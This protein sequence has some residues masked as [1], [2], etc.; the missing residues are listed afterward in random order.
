MFR[1]SLTIAFVLIFVL[2]ASS[3]SAQ[4]VLNEFSIA[5]YDGFQ[6][7]GDY[8]DWVEIY[9][10]TGAAIDAGGY[11]LSDNP[12]NPTKFE[13]PAG[14]NVPAGGYLIILLTND[15]DADPFMYGYLN[16]TFRVNQTQ[17]ESVI[18]ADPGGA[19]LTEWAF[20][21]VISP[22]QRNHSYG[23]IGDGAADWGI[24]TNPTPGGNN[25]T[26]AFT[27]YAAVPQFDTDAGYFAG[28]LTVGISAE[29]GSDIYYTTDGTDPDP[30]DQLYT[31]PIT[32][33]QT[34]VIRAIAYPND[35]DL[36]PSFV[37]TNTYFTGDDQHSV[38]VC[39][40]SGPTLSDG[41]WFGDEFMAIEMFH[42]NG[43]FWTEAAGDS[44]EHGNDSNAY[45]Q[46]GFDYVGR[47]ELGYKH[48]IDE[49]LFHVKERDL[50]QRL[51]F[52]AAANDNYPFE[53]GAHIRD[54]FVQ[55]LSHN[56]ELRLDERTN[57]SCI[58]YINGEYWGVYEYR[59]K[60]DDLDFTEEYYDQSRHFV[61]FIKTWGGTWEE[62][63]SIDDWNTLV[64]F[65][66]TNDM[67][68]PANYDYV[69]S[70][71]NT[72]SLIDYF[73]LNSYIVSADW[74]NW[75]TGWWRGRHPDGDA[76][77]WRYILWDMDASFG[78]Y[79]NYTGV[80]DTGPSA[81]PC[82]PET[83]NDPG[84]Q[85]HTNI[86]NALMEN[87]IFF[88]DYINRWADLNAS[89]FS[90]DYMNFLLDSMINVIEPEMTRQFER[91]GGSYAGW[92]GE[93]DELY[94]FIN[95]RCP[96]VS[97]DD[98]V[99]DEGIVDCYDVEPITITIIIQG[100]GEVEVEAFDVTPDMIP[101]EATYYANLPID[102]DAEEDLEGIF[103]YWE[104]IEGD[105]VIDDINNPDIQITP[106][107]D[108]TIVAW[109]TDNIE[110]QPVMFDVQPEGAGDILVAAQSVA[111]YPNTIIVEGGLN[112]F[113]AVP[114][115]EWFVFSHWETIHAN[116]MPSDEDPETTAMIALPDTVVAVF[117]ELPNA[118]LY[119]DVQPPGAGWI[120]IDG[121]E[122]ATYPLLDTLA[123]E[124]DF[125]FQTGG[126]DQWT[127]FSHWEVNHAPI[128][129]DEFAEQITL[130]F[131]QDDTVIAVYEIIPN[132]TTTVRVEPAQAGRVL[133]ADQLMVEDE[134]TG[135]LEGDTPLNFRAQAD[136]F[137]FF[138]SWEAV[139]HAPDGGAEAPDVEF[140]LNIPDTIVAHFVEEPFNVFVPNSFT[141]N[142]DGINDV[143]K[144]EGSAWEPGSFEIWIYNRWGQLVY[145]STDPEEVWLGNANQGTHYVED[146]I[147]VYRL[148]VKSVHRV[149]PQEYSGHIT[150]IR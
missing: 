42:P 92:Q 60:V 41:E 142:N 138:D 109:F 14:N 134:W 26:N 53:P 27:G 18:F 65:I 4:L 70:V 121:T 68:D 98:D 89:Y 91:W 111:P 99:L 71:L 79:I 86:F 2:G 16:T 5:N 108:V 80:P 110:P 135:Q 119:V 127:V 23:R 95:E 133:V 31:G 46:R 25:G 120:T 48:E 145:N 40:V 136:Q 30:G 100:L 72:R 73:I 83:L 29:P 20:G 144:A 78:H 131:S 64:D 149:E 36:L 13:I 106:S 37:E 105:L 140:T 76:K 122:I 147:Y 85:G 128:N 117:E 24:F 45:G 87:E 97:E 132:Y 143:F 129:P 123:A 125:V 102:L 32:V 96:N 28:G 124:Q 17:G 11:F 59:E 15:Y 63:G 51:I 69:E 22:N 74:L 7:G 3:M 84:G 67:S 12:A 49:Q 50:Y 58:V 126:G 115:N 66:M 146:E 56:A 39:S 93:V 141:P 47:D 19:I 107:G 113:E 139:Y 130:N 101:W 118:E 6:T 137:W 114:E 94:S 1:N 62:Y 104:V 43:E 34:T 112:T 33:D 55:T 88:S 10:P 21:T 148:H 35:G 44:N 75:N 54:A 82:N 103:L 61:D 150:V 90:C 9:N 38:I 77:R 52:K 81:A 116:M 8:E 57:E